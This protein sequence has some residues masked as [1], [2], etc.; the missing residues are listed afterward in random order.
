MKLNQDFAGWT[1]QTA[2]A[3]HLSEWAITELLIMDHY[4]RNSIPKGY[5][6]TRRQGTDMPR[7]GPNAPVKVITAAQL[8]DSP[9][10]HS[11]VSGVRCRSCG[12]NARRDETDTRWLIVNGTAYCLKDECIEDAEN[13][14]GVEVRKMVYGIELNNGE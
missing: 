2:F 5:R 9:D 7:P 4:E 11:P 1:R 12:H 6:N 14:H 13:V 10:Y 8:C 3:I